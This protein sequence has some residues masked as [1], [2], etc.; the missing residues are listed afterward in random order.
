MHAT[1]QLFTCAIVTKQY[2][3]VNSL[4]RKGTHRSSI[5]Q[6]I[7]HRQ[8]WYFHLGANGLGKEHVH[9]IH[10]P[11][12]L[13]LTCS[14]CHFLCYGCRN[15]CLTHLINILTAKWSMAESP[16][17]HCHLCRW[18]L[19]HIISM[20]W[21]QQQPCIYTF[22]QTEARVALFGLCWE[23]SLLHTCRES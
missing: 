1:L 6:A 22:W 9:S 2:F 12:L 10:A 21:P 5:S 16:T 7:R 13:Y 23:T 3:I 14:Y 15:V 4:H 11:L 20:T 8:Q 17:R 19:Y 18:A